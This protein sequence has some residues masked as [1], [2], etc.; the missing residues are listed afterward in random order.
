MLVGLPFNRM[1]K[2][3]KMIDDL[4]VDPQISISFS[5]DFSFSKKQGPMHCLCTDAR[6][7][8]VH[9]CSNN[10]VPQPTTNLIL[11]SELSSNYTPL[12]HLQIGKFKWVKALP[13]RFCADETLYR[14]LKYNSILNFIVWELN[15]DMKLKYNQAV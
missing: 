7:M 15:D 10:I 1:M 9:V 6:V 11:G 4:R 2:K 3:F 8:L 5:V 14:N 12:S 13:H